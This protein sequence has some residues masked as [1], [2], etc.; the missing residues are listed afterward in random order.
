MSTLDILDRRLVSQA[1]APATMIN[2]PGSGTGV[3]SSGGFGCG[4][5]GGSGGSGVFGSSGGGGVL[6][7]VGGSV[8][9]AEGGSDGG[10]DSVS[11]GTTLGGSGSLE[12]PP[13]SG[14]PSSRIPAMGRPEC[15]A[16]RSGPRGSRGRRRR[17]PACAGIG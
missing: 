17:T 7:S 14:R 9:G 2:V 10:F 8:G 3:G 4:D 15:R 12:P 6:R 11:C 16:I 13:R 1:A 5:S